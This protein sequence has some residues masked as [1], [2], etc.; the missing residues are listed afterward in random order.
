MSAPPLQIIL[1]TR[2]QTPTIHQAYQE[3]HDAL[4]GQPAADL[5][6]SGLTDAIDLEQLDADLVIVVGGDGAILRACRQLGSR[7]IPILGINLGRLG[8]LAD[9]T[10]A[11]FHQQVD[12][13]AGRDYRVIEHLMFECI[14]HRADGTQDQFLGLNEVAL[15]SAGALKMIDIQLTIGDEDVTSFSGDGLII[16]TP[17]GSTAH[18]LSAGGP[19]LRQDLRAF[20]VTPVCP[21]TLT[22]RPIVDRA[23]C[24]Y[25]LAMTE[26]PQG[27]HLVIDG[28]IK[29]PFQQGDRVEVRPA[30]ATFQLARLTGFSYYSTL[31]K[32][33]DWG[34]DP[35]YRRN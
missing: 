33:L 25:G 12:A 11:E 13:I 29:R 15:L 18:S 3:V 2:D 30:S 26:V 23:D 19:I 21:H 6:A 8:F 1:V 5:V 32:K 20:V 24:S 14:H 9:L 27:T 17:V 31:Q 4:S 7:Q 28:Q 35:R 34:R 10:L 22:N 16:A